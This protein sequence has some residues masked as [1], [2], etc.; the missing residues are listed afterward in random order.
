MKVKGKIHWREDAKNLSFEEFYK[1]HEGFFDDEDE[2]K[3]VYKEIT[4]LDPIK[5][6]K[7]NKPAAKNEAE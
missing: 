5:K 2:A 6:P 1:F 3:T 7:P 4:G